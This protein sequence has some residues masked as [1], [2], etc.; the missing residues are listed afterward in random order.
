MTVSHKFVMIVKGSL[1][2]FKGMRSL[3]KV[4]NVIRAEKWRIEGTDCG[5]VH[6]I[7]RSLYP[8][9]VIEG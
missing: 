4:K 7:S 8:F 9:I 5:S 1:E 3:L 6:L 2:A